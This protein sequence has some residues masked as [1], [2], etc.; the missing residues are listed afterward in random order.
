MAYRIIRVRGHWEVYVE[1][2]FICSADKWNE[3]VMEAE[4]YLAERR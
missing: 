3:A 4:M 2:E 1:G